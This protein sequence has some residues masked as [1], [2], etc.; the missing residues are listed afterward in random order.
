M[1]RVNYV[2]E[3]R[4]FHAFAAR[5]RLTANE[6][7]LWH[8]L[9]EIFNR[10]A[11][12]NEW[13]AG[14]LDISNS[15]LLAHTSFGAG[16]SACDILR[17]SRAGLQ[18]HGLIEVVKGRRNSLMPRYKMRYFSVPDGRETDAPGLDAPEKTPGHAGKD[19]AREDTKNEASPQASPAPHPINPNPKA[20]PNRSH[21][22]C[23]VPA[24]NPQGPFRYF[25]EPPATLEF[26]LAWKTSARA[27]G[28]V[29]QRLLDRYEGD[30]NQPDAWD[31]LCEV[32]E[33]GLPP[34]AV[35]RV[36][37]EKPLFNQLIASLRALAHVLR[38]GDGGLKRLMK[39]FE[40]T[41]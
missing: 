23:T 2:A 8:G 17:R 37:P 18:K 28:A 21:I 4:A 38:H 14:F 16:D 15:V 7:M 10:E 11:R 5:N 27:R 39:R 31:A 33:M 29:A 30:I 22:A 1:A 36:M 32:M 3:C 9:L 19:A 13:P 26:D 20:N 12:G 24:V 35:L 40:N 34:D 41:G 6:F 25:M